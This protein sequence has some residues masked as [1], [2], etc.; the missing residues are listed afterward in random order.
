MLV[1]QREKGKK[2]LNLLI[3]NGQ[4]GLIISYLNKIDLK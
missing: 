3:K 4:A 1:V 2:Y